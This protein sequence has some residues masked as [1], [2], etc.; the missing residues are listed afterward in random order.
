M[1]IKF[2]RDNPNPTS[3]FLRESIITEA[4]VSFITSLCNNLSMP[5][6]VSYL[7]KSG[8]TV[9]DMKNFFIQQVRILQVCKARLER[10]PA[11]DHT[12]QFMPEGI[13]RILCEECLENDKVCASCVEQKQPSHIPSLRACQRCIDS[14]EQC[15]R[16]AVLVLTTD[17]EEGNKKAMELILKMQEKHFDPALQYLVFILDSV[18]VGKSLKC[19][20]CNWF[21]IHREGMFGRGSDFKR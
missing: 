18:H 21:I 2:V 7:T 1:D 13:C 11:K 10:I 12:G 9:E 19:S 14:G 15:L 17:C 3:E 20:F 16:C 8:K 6:A 4:N 5:V